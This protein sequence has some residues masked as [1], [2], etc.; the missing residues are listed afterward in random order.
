[1]T[2]EKT[3]K[4]R[5]DQFYED[6]STAELKEALA[7]L[8]R[9]TAKDQ[10]E[11]DSGSLHADTQVDV[12]RIIK[13]D[14]RE[15]AYLKERLGKADGPPKGATSVSKS[16][17][18]DSSDAPR[19][20]TDDDRDDW[21]VRTIVDPDDARCLILAKRRSAG[22]PDTLFDSYDAEAAKRDRKLF[23]YLCRLGLER[24]TMNRITASEDSIAKALGWSRKKVR[25]GLAS[26]ER[27]G[28]I[29]RRNPGKGKWANGHRVGSV[30]TLPGLGPDPEWVQDQWDTLV[31]LVAVG[32]VWSP[33]YRELLDPDATKK[34][35][36]K[37]SKGGR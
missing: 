21:K 35:S 5:L 23:R 20:P 25:N 12:E 30:F 13:S 4:Q 14:R 6:H 29:G 17:G 10:E 36:K 19:I 18:R 15:I 24:G 16:S 7:D 22:R 33:D 28:L 37:R 3:L 31:E 27:Q 1:M 26:L 32:Y 34:R 9:A 11:I 2:T 8:K